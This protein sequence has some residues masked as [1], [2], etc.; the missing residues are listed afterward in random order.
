MKSLNLS[1][2]RVATVDDE[3]YERCSLFKWSL[4]TK[5]KDDGA[6]SYYAIRAVRRLDGTKEK[7]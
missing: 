6:I 2:S 7:R 5:V 1:Q 3:D 4:D